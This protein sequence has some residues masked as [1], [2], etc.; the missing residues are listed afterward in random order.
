MRDINRRTFLAGLAATAARKTRA[1]APTVLQIEFTGPQEIRDTHE[2]IAR[3]FMA[4]RPDIHIRLSTLPGDYDLALQ[5]ILRDAT[6]GSLPDISFQG[7]NNVRL[8]AGRGVAQPLTRFLPPSS[9]LSQIGYSPSILTVGTVGADLVAMPFC[10]AL[11]VIFYN[12][13]AVRSAGG[14]P[15][16]L[17]TTWD[18]I[19]SLARR[20]DAPAGGLFF[21]YEAN[22]NW[23]FISLL[24][25]LGGR[26]MQDDDRTIAFDSPEGLEALQLLARIGGLAKV[27]MTRMQARQAFGAGALGMHVSSSAILGEFIQQAGDRFTVGTGPFP[28]QKPDARLPA[29]GNS[30]IVHTKDPDRQEAC[31]AYLRYATA[32]TSQTLMAEQ[33]GYIP[34]NSLAVSRDDLLGQFYKT[35]PNYLPAVR[36][37]PAMGAWYGFIGQNALQINKVILNHLYAV[38]TGE[39]SP[40]TAL[41]S[42]RG[43]VAALLAS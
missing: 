40:E 21:E 23:L 4:E 15:E 42:M 24:Q 10:V 28:L 25:S 12:A 22:G 2:K 11:P 6:V 35:H 3:A 41:L 1:D 18:E 5:Q 31:W 29:A 38:V 37:F 43:A 16:Q 39:R 8:L 32:P 7:T 19:I 13:D 30:A 9:E 36:E 33:T 34:V 26:L 17:P 14:D 27:N 20:I